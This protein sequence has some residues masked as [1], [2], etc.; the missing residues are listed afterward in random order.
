MPTLRPLKRSY[1]IA[2]FR[3][4]ADWAP[5]QSDTPVPTGQSSS[6]AR[7]KQIPNPQPG[8]KAVRSKDNSKET[9][10]DTE[11]DTLSGQQSDDGET[12]GMETDASQYF[13]SFKLLS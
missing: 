1:A 13:S 6:W 9:F 10:D 5:S 11:M 12:T 3:E 2:D 4:C 7:G 8:I